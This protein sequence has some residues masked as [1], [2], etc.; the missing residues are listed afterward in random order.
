MSGELSVLPDASVATT[1][2]LCFPSFALNFAGEAHGFNG[3]LSNLHWNVEPG[4]S[5]VNSYFAF[6]FFLFVL[7][8]FFGYLVI[9]V[10]GGSV[11][12]GG[13]AAAAT[14]AVSALS[15]TLVC[16]AWVAETRTRSVAPTSAA[17][18][19]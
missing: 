18:G 15:I 1:W 17:V 19:V 14:A 11:S 12:G 5:E 7:S 6:V 4:S 10:S 13:C 2:N 9:V 8:L 3:F 16:P